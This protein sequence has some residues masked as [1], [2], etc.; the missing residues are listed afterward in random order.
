M[1]SI[2]RIKN[3]VF[4]LLV[5]LLLSLPLNAQTGTLFHGCAPEGDATQTTRS[6]PALNVLK[7]RTALPSGGFTAAH[8]DDLAQLEV[9]EGVSKKHRDRWPV[10]TLQAVEAQEK[11]AVQ[12]IGFLLKTKLEGPEGPNCHSTD[13][14]DRDFHIWLA[15][16]PDDDKPDAIVVEITPRVRAEHP[17]W[18]RTRLNGLIAGKTRVRVSGWVLL[19][20]E[21]PDQV[22]KTRATIWEIHPIMKIEV[23]SSGQWQEF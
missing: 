17:S 21:H 1:K 5:S 11:S 8:F 6:D 23:F 10:E 15:N 3:L 13:P 4:I 12:V 14:A 22:G 9:P 2:P 20:P 16:S 7:N 18:T 19:D